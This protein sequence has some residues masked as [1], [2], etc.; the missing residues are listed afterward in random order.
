MWLSTASP[1]RTGPFPSADFRKGCTSCGRQ[2]HAEWQRDTRGSNH[3]WY[4]YLSTK[5]EAGSSRRRYSRRRHL[6]FSR[7]PSRRRIHRL[8]LRRIRI[9]RCREGRT[10]GQVIRTGWKSGQGSS[11]CQ[12]QWQQAFTFSG[13]DDVWVFI[14]GQLALDLGG[15]HGRV[16][17]CINFSHD[18]AYSYKYNTKS[19]GG[20][21]YTSSVPAMSSFVS[22]VKNSLASTEYPIGTG[23]TESLSNLISSL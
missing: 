9:R 2:E 3:F 4:R 18:T 5:T 6:R 16:S 11:F 12:E 15:D 20:Y 22:A 23:K 19:G 13:D 10:S 17:G 1:T 8:H 7:K 14:E 21:E